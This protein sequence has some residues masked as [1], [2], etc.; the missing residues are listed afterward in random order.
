MIQMNLK[1]LLIGG[2]VAY[3]VTQRSATSKSKSVDNK[4]KVFIKPGYTITDCKIIKINDAEKA[5]KQAFKYGANYKKPEDID[6][7]LFGSTNCKLSLDIQ[8]IK[9]HPEKG[10]FFYD[11]SIY[12]LSGALNAGKV[13]L[14]DFVLGL[15]INREEFAKENISTVGWLTEKDIPAIIEKNK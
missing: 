6:N 10:K 9:A 14:E 1:P 2:I 3:F 12:Y 8:D 7:C 5:L 4:P 13:K 11:L 15:A